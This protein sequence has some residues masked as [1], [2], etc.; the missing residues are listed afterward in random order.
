VRV[1]YTI[2][3]S[4]DT[5]PLFGFDVNNQYIAG[6]DIGAWGTTL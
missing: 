5:A 2:V 3:T 1:N 4:V 6:F